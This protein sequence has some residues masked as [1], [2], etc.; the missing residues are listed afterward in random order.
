MALVKLRLI[1]NFCLNLNIKAKTTKL[2]EE[3]TSVNLHDHG[4]G[5]GFLDMTQ[6]HKETK[7]KTD[8]SEFIRI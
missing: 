7:K 2:L 1:L 4:L 6:K 3:N 5:Y 8:E